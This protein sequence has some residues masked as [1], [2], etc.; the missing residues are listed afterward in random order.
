MKRKDLIPIIKGKGIQNE[1]LSRALVTEL[2]R[3]ERLDTECVDLPA[4]TQTISKFLSKVRQKYNL[5]N[6]M[7]DRLEINESHWLQAEIQVQKVCPQ[8]GSRGRPRKSWEKLGDRS[9]RK[10]C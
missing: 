5:H 3:N 10:S 8:S 1:E 7:S 6:R 2:L 4:L 9:N